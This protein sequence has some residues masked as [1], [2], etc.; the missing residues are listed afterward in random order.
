MSNCNNCKHETECNHNERYDYMGTVIID[1]QT[2]KEYTS[3]KDISELLNELN[4]KCANY[5]QALLDLGINVKILD[6]D[7]T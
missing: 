2:D 7:E 4:S 5:R 3:Y 1:Y 6:G